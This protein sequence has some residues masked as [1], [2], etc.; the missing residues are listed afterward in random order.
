MPITNSANFV[1]SVLNNGYI[2]LLFDTGICIY[3]ES[4]TLDLIQFVDFGSNGRLNTV[5]SMDAVGNVL[6]YSIG[7]LIVVMSNELLPTFV[8]VYQTT[9]S[10]QIDDLRIFNNLF[11][12][13]MSNGMISQFDMDI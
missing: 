6:A 10:A 1:R 4:Q 3:D 9:F 5:Y 11:L 7:S 8:D 12:I 2:Y 13:V